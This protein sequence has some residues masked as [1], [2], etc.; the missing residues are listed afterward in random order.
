MGALEERERGVGKMEIEGEE[1]WAAAVEEMGKR[2][3]GEEE[4]AGWRRRRGDGGHTNA[5]DIPLFFLF[6]FS[7]IYI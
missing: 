5:P 3:E 1:E 7:S 2:R 6:F 4:G